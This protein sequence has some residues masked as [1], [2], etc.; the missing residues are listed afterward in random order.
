MEERRLCSYLSERV[1]RRLS[2]PAIPYFFE[3]RDMMIAQKGSKDRMKIGGE[4]HLL[5]NTKS[6]IALRT[7]S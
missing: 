3:K 2:R 5:R 4:S 1:R 6:P 7:Q